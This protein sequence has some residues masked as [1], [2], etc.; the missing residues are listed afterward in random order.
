MGEFYASF[1]KSKWFP[2]II[3]ILSLIFGIISLLNP[4]GR[5][6]IIA[7]IAGILFLLYGLLQ[8][9]RG[10]RIKENLAVKIGYIIL[11]LVIIVIA[12]L[13][14]VNLELV[15]KY[16]PTL[17]GFFMIVCAI[18]NLLS[19]FALM[20]NGIKGWWLGALPSII[21][22]VLG[23]IFLLNPGYVGKA[24]GIFVGIA[25]IF[26]GISNLISF[27]QMKK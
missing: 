4:A 17:A 15:G 26:N 8:V 9:L 13:D 21:L 19:S 20:K 24:F 18:S 12:I 25:L 2:L 1:K 3:G 11:G 16:F 5:M 6:E 14:F 7:L 22:L 23:F 27:F 10:I